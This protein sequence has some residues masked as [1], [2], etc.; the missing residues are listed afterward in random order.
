MSAN[1]I[2][3]AVP[4]QAGRR[5]LPDARLSLG[6]AKLDDLFPEGAAFQQSIQT[7]VVLLALS[8][9][10]ASFGLFQ[11]STAAVIGAML[12]APLGGA[13]MA[14]AGALV[15]GRS[16]WQL[17]T[18]LQV[19]LGGLLVVATGYVVSMIV[20]DPLTLTPALAARTSPGMLDLGVALAAGA[21]GAYVA[22]RRTG[23]DALPGVAIAVSLVPPLATA[24]ICLELGRISDAA[25]ALLLFLTNFAAIVVIASIVFVLFGNAPSPQMLRERHR[26]RNGFIAAV[27]MLVIVTIPLAIHSARGI[28]NLIRAA[29][30]APIISDWIGTRDLDVTTWAVDGDTVTLAVAGPDA[31]ASADALAASLAEAFGARVELDVRYMPVTHE[32]A[33]ATP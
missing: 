22:A 27:V 5:P 15:T 25:G 29:I 20:P 23:T 21:A 31:P 18:F 8:A 19:A 4:A 7:Y 1:A 3:P 24:G 32:A 14:L 12:V 33:T 28:Q 30:G 9:L 17:I 2:P 13:I 10:L 6:L 16:R 26:L 11:D